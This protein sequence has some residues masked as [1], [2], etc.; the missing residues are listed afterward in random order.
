MFAVS[1]VYKNPYVG[2]LLKALVVFLF[3]Y[4]LRFPFKRVFS[5]KITLIKKMQ[6]QRI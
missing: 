5:I 3:F 6:D 4:L 1:N 2:T